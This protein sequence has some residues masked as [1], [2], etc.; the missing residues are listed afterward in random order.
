[1][2][3]LQLPEKEML[4]LL[5]TCQAGAPAPGSPKL[6]GKGE[7]GLTGGSCTASCWEVTRKT[8]KFSATC[9]LAFVKWIGGTD[10][11]G[12]TLVCLQTCQDTKPVWE[13][14]FSKIMWYFPAH[15]AFWCEDTL[16]KHLKAEIICENKVTLKSPVYLI[17][18]IFVHSSA[19]LTAL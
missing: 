4:E 5:G 1:M 17:F 3:L 6:T 19:Y 2:W 14:T 8:A 15:S 11:G 7:T 13:L 9:W 10:S 18:L 16:E 12:N